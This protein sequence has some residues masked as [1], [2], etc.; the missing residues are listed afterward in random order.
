MQSW[1]IFLSV[2]L[3]FN[4]LTNICL[5]VIRYRLEEKGL[6]A[7][8]VENFKWM[9]MFAIFFGG[10]SFHLNLA[11]LAHMFSIDMQWGATNKE[12]TV[13]NFFQ[14]MPKIF[15]SFKWLYMI[16]VLLTGAM[17]YFGCFAPTGWRIT[18]IVAVVPLA[19]MIG[20]HYLFPIVLNPGL[21]VFNY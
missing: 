8:L 18:E 4:V 3:V 11:I 15:K 14:E 6:W 21:M 19:V 7:S 1:N 5:A 10:L 9:P 2:I 17:I 16:L 12:K 13:T 20:S